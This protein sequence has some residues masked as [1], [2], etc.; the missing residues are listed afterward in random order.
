MGVGVTERSHS[1]HNESLPGKRTISF[2]CSRLGRFLCGGRIKCREMTGLFFER[3]GSPFAFAPCPRDANRG[4]GQRVLVL[5]GSPRG[6]VTLLQTGH[7]QP[8]NGVQGFLVV[9]A[10]CAASP[11]GLTL[12]SRGTRLVG[13]S[14][15]HGSHHGWRAVL[16]SSWACPLI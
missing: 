5:Y 10:S 2:T 16:T 9:G 15:G 7:I 8:V 3:T 6:R 14:Q 11:Q 4:H 1:A 12:H 13:A